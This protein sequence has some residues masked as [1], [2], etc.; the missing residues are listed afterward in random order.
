MDLASLTWHG[1]FQGRIKVVV[2]PRQSLIFAEQTGLW[3]D[4][5][6]SLFIIYTPI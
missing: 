2:G 3:V 5:H 4:S 6:S 1:S